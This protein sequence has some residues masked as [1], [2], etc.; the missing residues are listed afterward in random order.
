MHFSLET[1]AQKKVLATSALIVALGFGGCAFLDNMMT[2]NGVLFA[3]PGP[4]AEQS[5]PTSSYLSPSSPYYTSP[6]Q[7]QKNLEY[8]RDNPEAA[9]RNA[10]QKIRV[11]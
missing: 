3:P 1:R 6:E 4:P 11:R 7:R 2:G 5:A 8:L 9:E 10:K